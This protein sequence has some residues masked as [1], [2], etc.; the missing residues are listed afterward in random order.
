MLEISDLC[1][2]VAG[3]P[4]LHDINLSLG[5]GE[6]HVLLGPNGS[7]KSSLLATILGLPGYRITRGEIR[8]DGAPLRDLSLQERAE[9][10]I[11]M[12]FQRPPSMGG[13]SV[14]AFAAALGASDILESEAAAL[15]LS[16]FVTRDMNVGFSGGEIKRWEILK[17]FLQDP[18]LMLF[19]E[20]ESGVDLEHV[21]AIGQAI[22]RITRSNDRKGRPRAGLVIT[23]TGLILNYVEADRA[24]IMKGGRLLHSG[25]PEALFRHIQ[26]HGYTVPAAA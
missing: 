15:D 4:V 6:L 12:A 3:Q 18:R 9:L 10:G 5:E 2:E 16:D 8:F 14:S 13:V 7:G 21:S 19:D 20:P 1:V 24:H 17:L 11:G 22:R 23:H 25:E 26:S